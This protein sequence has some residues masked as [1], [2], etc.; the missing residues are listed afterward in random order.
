MWMGFTKNNHLML[1]IGIANAIYAVIIFIGMDER[2]L[3]CK[4][5]MQLNYNV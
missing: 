4:G 1:C 3:M 2:H 5:P